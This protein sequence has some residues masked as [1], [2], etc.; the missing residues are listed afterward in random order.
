MHIFWMN[1]AHW[2][3]SVVPLALTPESVALLCGILTGKQMYAV[4]PW[5]LCTPS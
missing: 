2:H 1:E 5:Q 4:A 3:A